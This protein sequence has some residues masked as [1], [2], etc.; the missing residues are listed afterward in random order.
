[1]EESDK[2]KGVKLPYF[3]RKLSAE[4]TD[5][6]GDISPKPIDSVSETAAAGADVASER[7][8]TKLS[9]GSAW[10]TANTWEERDCTEWALEHLPELFTSSETLPSTNQY[11]VTVTTVDNTA[12]SAQIAHVRGKA[13][14]IYELSFDL[15]YTVT[16]SQSDKKYSGKVVVTDVINDQLDDLDMQVT[17]K[18]ASPPGK[19]L[20]VVRNS[21]MGG[22]ALK[23]LIVARMA[24]FEEDFRNK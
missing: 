2:A 10:N 24:I 21:I 8:T 23:K 1:M 6:I 4:E 11:S 14:F 20:V 3:H 17:W 16:D 13:R 18:G 12:G 22:Q 19:E 15:A 5:L 9:N 7:N